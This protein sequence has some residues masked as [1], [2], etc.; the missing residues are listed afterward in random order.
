MSQLGRISGPLLKDNLIR[1]GV[2]LRISNTELSTSLLY[3]N[4]NDR[5]I[6]INTAG[7]Q[8][9][10]VDSTTK[11]INL[12]SSG[13]KVANIEFALAGN[14]I[15]STTS[16]GI[17]LTPNQT[18]PLI[19]ADQ[20]RAGD[21]NLKD[22]VV[23]NYQVNGSIELRANS[24]RLV[25]FDSSTTINGDLLV[26]GNINI[27]G[28]LTKNGDLI[29]GDNGDTVTVAP[30][31]RQSIIPGIDLTYD[32]GTVSKRWRK[33]YVDNNS[34]I[35]SLSYTSITVGDQLQMDGLT[36]QIYTLQ[37]NDSV[38]LNP[39]TGI[40]DTESIR[41]QENDITNLNSDTVFS[42]N[43]TGIGYVRFMGTNGVVIPAGSTPER[44]LA[45]EVG[46]TR[47]NTDIGRLECWDGSVYIVATGPGATIGEVDMT[48]LQFVY[49][50]M[51]G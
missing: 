25:N 18:D 44:P 31:F 51:L 48:D 27:D 35:T 6:S 39:D 50:V 16:G 36:R 43:S 33:I 45:P 23:S 47:W 4:V 26:T 17:T 28:S 2:D 30:N 15:I 32:L 12:I 14:N 7:E 38:L 10:T 49:A 42:I 40:V 19:V 3:F 8:D 37:S 5:Q 34:D 29:I 20:L 46:D 21:I 1:D 22:N 9:L 13:I 11:T 41:F 24:N